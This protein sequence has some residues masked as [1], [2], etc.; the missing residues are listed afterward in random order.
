VALRTI[1]V[2]SE[3]NTV[4]VTELDGVPYTLTFWSNTRSGRLFVDLSDA[5]GEPL[6]MGVNLVLLIDLLAG[7][8]YRTDLPPGPLVVVPLGTDY[9]DPETYP[10]FNARCSLVYN[11]AAPEE[12]DG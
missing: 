5:N 3:P 11:D 9:T 4:Q 1:P 8:R 10:E 2:P 12:E 6:A 7:H